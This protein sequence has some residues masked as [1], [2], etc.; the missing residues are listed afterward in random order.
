MTARETMSGRPEVADV[1]VL[2]AELLQQALEHRSRRAARTLV[3]GNSQRVTLIALAE[4]AE[5]AEHDSP[6]AATLHVITGSVRLST[7]DHDRLLDRGQL[8]AIPPERHRLTAF[9][10]SAVLLTVALH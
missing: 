5:L 1:G 2:A 6:P 3:A 7:H 8:T 9:L 4:G 10:D